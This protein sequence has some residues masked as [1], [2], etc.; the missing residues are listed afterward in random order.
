MKQSKQI[1]LSIMASMLLCSNLYGEQNL[2]KLT[3]TAQKTEE[4]IQDVP[5]SITLFD[6][7]KVKDKNIE[8][9][10]DIAAHTPNLM[11]FSYG[12]DNQ[13]SPSLR[14]VFADIESKVSPT[15][16]YIDGVPV[17]DAWSMNE[18]LN[19]IER[20]EVLKGPQGTLY[21][22]NSETGVINIY[23]KEPSNETQA[24][25]ELEY[26]TDNKQK[27]NV[28]ASGALIEDKLLMGL[29]ATH[30]EKE[31]FLKHATTGE[32]LDDRERNSGRLNLIYKPSDNLK[33]S[34]VSAKQK[35]NDGAIKMNGTNFAT[36]T[37]LNKDQITSNMQGYNKSE[38]FNNSLKVRYDLSDKSSIESV[39]TARDFKLKDGD[40]WDF[41]AATMG[42]HMKRDSRTKS[43]SQELRYN[44]SFFDDKLDFLSGVY[45]DKKDEDFDFAWGNIQF[46]E[47]FND[48]SIGLFTHSKYHVDNKLAI[49]GGIRYDS[50]R[51][52]FAH[53][54]NN[55]SMNNKYSEI[56][57]KLSVEYYLAKNILTYATIA[58]GYRA[59]GFNHMAPSG[60]QNL[61]FDKETL[62][63]YELGYKS[64]LLDNKLTLNAA[65]YYMDISDMQIKNA[66]TPGSE[67]VSN[68]AKAH[69]QGI[70]LE[71][72]Y[73]LNDEFSLSGAFGLNN[74]KYDDFKDSNGDYTGNTNIFSPKY[75]YNIGLQYRSMEGYYAR[76]D[77]NGYGKMYLDKENMY[78][79]KAYSLVNVKVGYESEDY[80]I[81]LYAKNLFDKNHDTINYSKYYT[82]YS[83]PR[84]VGI[85]IAYRF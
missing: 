37:L 62:W 76:A 77:L 29:S 30:Y 54:T 26:G 79:K 40:D 45:L 43:Y 81:Y 49:L 84:E 11:F 5:I 41:S 22:K 68:A 24:A 31:G 46:V 69:S 6:E 13:L 60:H 70:E 56:S 67:Y 63:N 17:V 8:R 50:E 75:N 16:V 42:F 58:K 3:V 61:S 34:F 18:D 14:G 12:A 1:G 25:I 85:Q 35:Y 10:E 55:V 51:K 59:G 32:T 2:D 64:T 47:D 57:P 74:T 23:T 48:K 65:L 52:K 80:D 19:N 71:A 15:A 20:I 39:T 72:D 33:I 53:H 9:I 83:D 27:I 82:I 4:N 28:S 21:G 44:G 78:E 73:K 38:I 66:A 7:I 36:M